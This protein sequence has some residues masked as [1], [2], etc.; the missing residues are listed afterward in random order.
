M[1]IDAPFWLSHVFGICNLVMVRS[2]CGGRSKRTVALSKRAVA[3]SISR[4]STSLTTRVS[5]VKILSTSATCPI[6]IILIGNKID[7]RS[8]EP[9]L[10]TDPSELTQAALEQQLAPVMA[11]FREVEF[12]IEA[13]AFLGM[14]EL[15]LAKDLPGV[16][17]GVAFPGAPRT[18][19][20]ALHGNGARSE[21]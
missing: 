2:K 10:S 20:D 5:Y 6:P 1:K 21:I 7:L 8:S 17:P 15:V 16:G 18:P 9:T 3:E 13:S 19:G 11:E 4:Q 12:C 14:K